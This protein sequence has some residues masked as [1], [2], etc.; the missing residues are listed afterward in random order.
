M[1]L[2]TEL[3]L[4]LQHMFKTLGKWNILPLNYP[5]QQSI[6]KKRNTIH[7]SAHPK[8]L[9]RDCIL[10]YVLFIITGF[11]SFLRAFIDGKSNSEKLI[12]IFFSYYSGTLL[13]KTWFYKSNIQSCCTFFNNLVDFE[14]QNFKK[15][16]IFLNGVLEFV[17]WKN[18]QTTRVVKYIIRLFT[19]SMRNHCIIHAL[20][21]ALVPSAAWNFV[22]SIILDL[23]PTCEK[24]Y[25][26]NI[27][28]KF[29]KRVILFIYIYITMR[30]FTNTATLHMLLNIFIP[31]FS[32]SA[33]LK[34]LQRNLKYSKLSG[35]FL[36]FFVTYR[37]IQ[38]LSNNYNNIYR[39]LSF[40]LQILG[41][42][43]CLSGSTTILIS[44][45][46]NTNYSALII[47]SNLAMVGCIE[48]LVCLHFA[49]MFNKISHSTIA[50]FKRK[51]LLFKVRAPIVIATLGNCNEPP[52]C[53]IHEKYMRSMVPLK[54][55]FLHS[56]YFDSL[57]P[58]VFF[59]FSLRLAIHFALI[60][61]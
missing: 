18:N 22:P 35:N 43:V 12:T 4:E 59:K 49:A 26:V 58:L 17:H 24:F 38:L 36:H 3:D 54:I 30:L 42:I 20:S 21:C 13:I 37:Q 25:F 16:E 56:N 10:Q 5:F 1:L 9:K 51:M 47:Y 19:E 53:A 50:L 48:I 6:K 61:K 29:L 34:L 55:K 23:F 40:P 57:T 45:F 27:T 11:L 2:C 52:R 8:F 28:L 14:I 46:S 60:S 15:S 31:T 41:G 33:F 7:V 39:K 44:K 32:L